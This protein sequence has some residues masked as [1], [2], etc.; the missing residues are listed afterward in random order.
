MSLAFNPF[1]D[2][3]FD[4]TKNIPIPQ[5]ELPI[6]PKIGMSDDDRLAVQGDDPQKA[7]E[8]TII[9]QQPDDDLQP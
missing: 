9:R 1:S 6:K 4:F 7:I 3:K 2:K 5:P 8:R